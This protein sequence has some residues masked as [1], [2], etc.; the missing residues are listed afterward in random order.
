MD[1]FKVAGAPINDF[2]LKL[3]ESL[4]ILKMK[5]CLYIAQK[6]MLLYLFDI[7]SGNSIGKYSI[8]IN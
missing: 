7:G 2:Y 8:M 3:K 6:K 1:N 5:P 4:L